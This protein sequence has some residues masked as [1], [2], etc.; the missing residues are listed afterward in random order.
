MYE[1]MNKRID[2]VRKKHPIIG[3]CGKYYKTY[4]RYNYD[5]HLT[6]FMF[7]LGIA[8]PCKA[9][10]IVPDNVEESK[11]LNNLLGVPGN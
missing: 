8:S 6:N 10:L 5:V 1:R 3:T 7:R 4:S 11:G 9:R 2:A